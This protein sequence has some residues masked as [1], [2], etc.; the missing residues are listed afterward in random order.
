M[1]TTAERRAAERLTVNMNTVC[2]LLSPVLE[3][4]GGARIKDVSNSGIGLIVNHK[5]EP[6]MLLA[7]NIANAT[8]SYSKT[9]L[10]RVMHVLPQAGNTYLIGGTFQTLLTYDELKTMVM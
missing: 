5:L 10:V 3:D 4:I 2:D 6:G 7:I 8:R 1:G 9:M